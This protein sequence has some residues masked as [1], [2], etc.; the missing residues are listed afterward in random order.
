M[1]R[2]LYP[3]MIFIFALAFSLLATSAVAQ[4]RLKAVLK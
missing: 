3:K 4:A 1:K 2:L